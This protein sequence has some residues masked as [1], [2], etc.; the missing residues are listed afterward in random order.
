[1]ITAG[2]GLLLRHLAED[3]DPSEHQILQKVRR[4]EA[5]IET[6][7]DAAAERRVA[8]EE[9]DRTRALNIL[10][11]VTRAAFPPGRRQSPTMTELLA[12]VLSQRFISEAAESRA[13]PR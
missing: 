3:A 12:I 4:A 6:Q 2:S 9:A 10:S 1:M 7:D 8:A 13:I 5:V 11:L